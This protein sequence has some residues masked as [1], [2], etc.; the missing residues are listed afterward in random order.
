MEY[1]AKG[2]KEEAEEA[3]RQMLRNA[4]ATRGLALKDMK[5]ASTEHVV[6]RIGCAFAGVALWY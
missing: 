2:T 5:L 6:D 1:A 4:F 3:I